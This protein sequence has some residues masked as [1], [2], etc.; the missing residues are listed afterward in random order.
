MADINTALIVCEPVKNAEI[1]KM[2]K[3][4]TAPVRATTNIRHIQDTELVL[5]IENDE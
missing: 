3:E 5:I 2:V 1:R 4:A